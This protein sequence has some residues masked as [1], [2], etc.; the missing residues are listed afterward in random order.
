MSFKVI[1]KFPDGAVLQVNDE[2]DI[3]SRS[4]TY[5]T[6]MTKKV[7]SGLKNDSSFVGRPDLILECVEFNDSD[8]YITF[9]DIKYGLEILVDPDSAKTR[10]NILIYQIDRCDI[11]SM[12]Y[13]NPEDTV[14]MM[15]VD[16]FKMEYV[17][18]DTKF[19]KIG[20]PYTITNINTGKHV[21][22]ALLKSMTLQNM[23][24]VYLRNGELVE[25][26]VGATEYKESKYEFTAYQSTP[27]STKGVDTDE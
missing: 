18:F 21:G 7:T 1:R 26:G 3:G 11:D 5:Y 6:I 14:L 22:P 8:G 17:P 2:W 23:E 16:W 25:Y 9:K 13:S 20:E 10:D 24:F 12:D 19:F 4:D 27:Q 15:K